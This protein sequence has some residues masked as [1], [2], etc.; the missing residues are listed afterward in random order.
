M[1]HRPTRR[2]QQHQQLPQQC[3]SPTVGRQLMQQ[4]NRWA[5]TDDKKQRMPRSHG[6]ASI[7]RHASNNTRTR[8]TRVRVIR[9][10]TFSSGVGNSETAQNSIPI[11][12]K[13]SP[14]NSI[15]YIYIY[16][17]YRTACQGLMT[18]AVNDG[19]LPFQKTLSNIN[20]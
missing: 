7:S 10:V 19:K 6:E 16:I 18:H 15:F 17:V 1:R 2:H 3:N 14:K 5:T 20:R 12:K 13:T 8:G 11:D 9:D 4:P